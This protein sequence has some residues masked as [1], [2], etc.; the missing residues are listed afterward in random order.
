MPSHD[1]LQVPAMDVEGQGFESVHPLD[2]R[3]GAKISALDPSV[4]RR[5]IADRER[6]MA[7]EETLEDEMSGSR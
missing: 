5:K 7:I 4:N 3:I 2:D 6:E 1:R